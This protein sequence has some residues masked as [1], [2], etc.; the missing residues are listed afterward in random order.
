[1]DCA[2]LKV[3]LQALRDR[4]TRLETHEH[5]GALGEHGVARNPKI[6]HSFPMDS[7]S[8]G[9]LVWELFGEH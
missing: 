3:Q 2:E 9:R 1:D 8:M 5:E 7:R 6:R 4:L